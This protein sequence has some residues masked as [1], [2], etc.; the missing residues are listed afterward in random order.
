MRRTNHTRQLP[1]ADMTPLVNIALLLIVF[2]VWVKQVQRPVTTLIQPFVKAKYESYA[3]VQ[4]T[5]FLL[6]HD[7]VGLLTYLPDSTAAEFKETDYSVNGL[8][9]SLAEVAKS[10]TRPVV[11]ITPTAQSTVKNIVDVLDE[12]AIN[13]RVHHTMVYEPLP[14]EKRMLDLYELY[15]QAK[16]ISP[17]LLHLPI[18]TYSPLTTKRT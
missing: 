1:R 8:R 7:R 3:P 5:L 2:F 14:G 15:R 16:P 4:A 11:I 17:F 18:Y 9:A 13:K 12:L 6:P 10:A